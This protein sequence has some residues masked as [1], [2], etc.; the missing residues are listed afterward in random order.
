MVK[1]T[2]KENNFVQ[3]IISIAGAL[4]IIGIVVLAFFIF[5]DNSE[6]SKIRNEFPSL[7]DEEVLVY[8]TIKLED[9]QELISI[10]DQFFILLGAKD[11]KNSDTIAFNMN[12]QAI[13][14]GVDKV[15]YLNLSKLNEAN[16]TTI[17]HAF[18][19]TNADLP[20]VAFMVNGVAIEK[21][22]T[23]ASGY[24]T[25]A[26]EFNWFISNSLE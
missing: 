7:K 25:V 19:I 13:L 4:A 23:Y 20:T 5:G 22:H 26:E 2:K 15:F 11:F 6:E 1:A 9:L 17:L 12:E 3:W 14:L 8:K 24:D 10:G 16:L 21:S 18:N